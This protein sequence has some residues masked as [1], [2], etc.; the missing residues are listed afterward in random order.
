MQCTLNL[1][2]LL[3]AEKAPL[4][5]TKITH[6]TGDTACRNIMLDSARSMALPPNYQVRRS[7]A[8]AQ[9]T[10]RPHALAISPGSP[11]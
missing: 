1:W 3:C 9:P 11:S 2:Q 10:R 4:C 8:P 5:Q 6:C 7:L